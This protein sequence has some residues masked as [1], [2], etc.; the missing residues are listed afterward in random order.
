MKTTTNVKCHRDG[1]VT[2]WDVYSQQWLRTDR[3]SDRVLAALG[4]EDRDRVQ[5]HLSRRGGLDAALRALR[6]RRTGQGGGFGQWMTLTN[7]RTPCARQSNAR[8]SR[9]GSLATTPTR[10]AKSASAARTGSTR[11]IWAH[12]TYPRPSARGNNRKDTMDTWHTLEE[13]GKFP[14]H[15]LDEHWQD[16]IGGY[17]RDE[18]GTP[19][20][21][22]PRDDGSADI[23]IIPESLA[24]MCSAYY[25]RGHDDGAKS[26]VSAIPGRRW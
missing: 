11:R 20:L 8:S 6:V 10:A 21:C 5:K 17:G 13:F 7:A 15:S 3:P 25:A 9:R 14:W 24:R 4:R 1:T 16:G 23:W 2:V 12:F 26:A 18:H 22:L 19:Y